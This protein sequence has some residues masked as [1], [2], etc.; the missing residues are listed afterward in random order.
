MRMAIE[1][2][3]FGL[4]PVP[5]PADEPYGIG[6]HARVDREGTACRSITRARIANPP[7]TLARRTTAAV[8]AL[9]HAR[10]RCASRRVDPSATCRT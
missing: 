1:T 3:V 6:E 7:R 10:W 5:A 4:V 8:L 9:P 2:S